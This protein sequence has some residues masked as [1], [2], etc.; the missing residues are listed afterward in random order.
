MK[1]KFRFIL[2]NV[3][4]QTNSF[5]GIFPFFRVMERFIYFKTENKLYLSN[6]VTN[7]YNLS[8]PEDFFVVIF[9]LSL[10]SSTEYCRFWFC[11]WFV[12]HLTETL[13]QL[14]SVFKC[15]RQKNCQYWLLF[16]SIHFSLFFCFLSQH[17]GSFRFFYFSIVK[18]H[19][20]KRIII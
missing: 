20:E 4:C 19:R 8:T 17:T 5:P 15:H 7:V 2:T 12:S 13:K 18:Q 10:F 1:K 11:I 9:I 16:T 14:S 6:L 3:K